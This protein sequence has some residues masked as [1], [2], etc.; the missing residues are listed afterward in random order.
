[1]FRRV[2]YNNSGYITISEFERLILEEMPNNDDKTISDAFYL[3][4]ENP[5]DNKISMQAFSKSIL[6]EVPL[7]SKEE[8]LYQETEWA[9][10]LFEDIMSKLEAKKVRPQDFFRNDT[11]TIQEAADKISSDLGIWER[12]GLHDLLKC[13]AL[14]DDGRTIETSDFLEIL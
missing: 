13:F 6:N 9:S 10:K 14:K 1:M 11:T 4:R 12:Q 7:E 8:I 3:I 5:Q 2:D